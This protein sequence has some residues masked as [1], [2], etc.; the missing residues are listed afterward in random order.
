MQKFQRK[1][2]W[3]GILIGAVLTFFTVFVLITVFLWLFFTGGPAK[4]TKDLKRYEE[5]FELS[6]N[7]GLIIFPEHISDK[8]VQ[9]DFYSY[10]RDMFGSPSY[11]IYLQCTYEPEEYQ[12]E[13][14]RLENTYKK[15]AGTERR[16]LKDTEGKYNYPAYIAIENHHY[17]YEY[18]LIT[19]E[20]QI[21]YISVSGRDKEK[22][23]FS[24]DYLPEDFMTEAGRNFTSGYSI[25]I[26]SISSDHISYDTTRAQTVTVRDAHMEQ[27]ED[28]Y[29]VVHV[30]LDEENREIITEC[31]FEHYE[32]QHDE[33]ADITVYSELNG[34]IYKDLR[35]NE[36]RTKA[37]IVYYEDKEQKQEKEF[38]VELP[39]P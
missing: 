35:L 10:Y 19:G 3:K 9:T 39:L 5:I 26:S 32:S 28:S 25:Y 33:E 14:E 4:T 20:N 34:M 2:L 22:V 30:E 8:A 29:F 18:A 16:L 1:K 15:Y 7:S 36:D 11:E 37:I 24:K 13:I 31:N 38:V 17:S 6:M 27:I 12:A 21:T 23:K